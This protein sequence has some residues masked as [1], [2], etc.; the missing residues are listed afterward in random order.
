MDESL[1]VAIAT[2]SGFLI[3]FFAEPVKIYFQQ[4]ARKESIRRALYHELYFN[5]ETF[6]KFAD[7]QEGEFT[8][9]ELHK[10]VFNAK[11]STHLEAYQYYL[12]HDLD[13]YYQLAE[14]MTL[15]WLYAI[16]NRLLD[17][18][19][20]R[21]ESKDDPVI[22][23]NEIKTYLGAYKDAIDTGKLN[24][25]LLIKIIGKDKYKFIQEKE[26]PRSK[27]K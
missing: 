27:E 17:N 13:L 5:Y 11:Y 2:I 24:K 23:L 9:K 16:V 19:R 15:N 18:V 6:R 10:F 4:K 25:Q 20:A 12:S 8:K 26:Y 14:A 22:V 7:K 1:K 21:F 3:A